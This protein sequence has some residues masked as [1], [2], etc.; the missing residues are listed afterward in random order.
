M[1]S[2]ATFARR[3]LPAAAALALLFS[4][5]KGAATAD[6]SRPVTF[7]VEPEVADL[8]FVEGDTTLPFLFLLR[9]EGGRTITIE[10]VSTTCGCTVAFLPDS[11]IPPGGAVPL[12]GTFE[13][14]KMEGKTRKAIFVRSDDETRPQAVLFLQIWIQRRLSWSPRKLNFPNVL[15]GESKEMI[16]LIRGATGL[17]F[18]VTGVD[19]PEGFSWAIE[20]GER[21]E[22]RLL[23]V[24]LLPRETAG[25]FR[26]ELT[27]RTNVEGRETIAVPI[28]GNVTGRRAP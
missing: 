9:N 22:D 1:R 28:I 8:G 18:A 12:S 15:S 11:T 14:R 19:V 6:G 26:E 21:P 17:P 25:R 10:E 5:G 24:T 7:V 16:V 23:H 4:L 2:A 20:T 27:I 13:T 3:A